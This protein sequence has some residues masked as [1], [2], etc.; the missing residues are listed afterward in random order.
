[1]DTA[2]NNATNDGTPADCQCTS[3]K[4]YIWLGMWLFE[5]AG[6][7]LDAKELSD[8]APVL[9]MKGYELK[10]AWYEVHCLAYCELW[11]PTWTIPV[12]LIR[13]ITDL[14]ALL[15]GID[16]TGHRIF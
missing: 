3:P 11:G 4:T 8:I 13:E 7:I 6:K 5:Q 15:G 1:M 9:L 14:V 10:E 2:T 12:V 16:L